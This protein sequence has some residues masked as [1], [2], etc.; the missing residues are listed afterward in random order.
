MASDSLTNNHPSALIV[1]QCRLR[2][3]RLP[4]KGLLPLAGLPLLTFLLRRLEEGL[5]SANEPIS[6][7]IKTKIV[8]ATSTEALDEVLAEW[9]EQERVAVVRGSNEDVLRR[10]INCLERFP[11]AQIVVRVTADNPFTCPT[12]LTRAVV[13]MLEESPDYLTLEG[14]PV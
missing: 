1:V 9:A 12:Q 14:F 7:N 8:L 5:S 3:H 4:G 6:E 10:Y 11:K 2:S 13:R